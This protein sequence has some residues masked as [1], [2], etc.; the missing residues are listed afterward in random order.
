MCERHRRSEKRHETAS[1]NIKTPKHSSKLKE[2][3]R[4]NSCTYTK[5]K[6]PKSLFKLEN[7]SLHHFFF[8]SSHSIHSPLSFDSNGVR[9]ASKSAAEGAVDVPFSAASDSAAEAVPASFGARVAGAPPCGARP[10]RSH[11]D[12]SV[13][14]R[15]RPPC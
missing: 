14:A 6:T 2:E 1:L 10:R 7:F 5:R 12:W 13:L 4:T 15:D 3:K 9:V 8:S 11:S